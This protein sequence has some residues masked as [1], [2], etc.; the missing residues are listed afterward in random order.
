MKVLRRPVRMRVVERLR[1]LFTRFVVLVVALGVSTFASAVPAAA[2][3]AT[4]AQD[5]ILKVLLFYKSNFHASHVQAR[6][7]V[8]SLANELSVEYGQ[9]VEIEETD[10]AAAFTTGNLATKDAVVFAQT[11]GVLFNTAQRE[12]LEQYIRGG[13]G[14]MGLHYAGW[15]VGQSEHDVNEFYA[16]L[17]GAASEGHPENPA[18][19]PGR[20]VVRDTNH[21]LTQGLAASHTRSDEWYDWLVNPAQNVRTLLSVDESSYSPAVG[22]QGTTHPVT[23][24]Q[25]IDN[26]RSWYTSMGHEGSHYSESYMRTQMRHGLAFATGLLAA[27][28]SPPRKDVQGSWGGVVP[29]PLMPINASLTAEGLVQS[30]GSVGGWGTDTT[31]YDWTGNSTVTQGG[32]FE[33]DVWDP[34]EPRNLANLHDHIVPNNTYTDLFCSMQVQ[35]PHRRTVMTMGGDDSLGT[36]DPVNAAI[37]VTSFSTKTGLV[38]EAPMHYPRWYP[39]ATTM[40][41]G[42]IAVQGGSVRGVSGPGVTTPELYSPNEGAGW[43]LLT[44]AQSSAAYGDTE[45]RW[46][47]PRAFVAPGSGNLFNISGTQMFDLDPYANDGKGKVTLRGTVPSAIADQGSDLGRPVGATSSA[48]MYQPG[49]ILQVGGG[50]WSNGGGGQGARGG[51]TIDITDG[52]ESPVVKATKPMQYHRHWSTATL[53]PDGNVIV[54]GGGAGNN[55]N[56]RYVTNP[57]IWDAATGE[58]ATVEVPYEHARLYHSIALLLPDGRVMIGGGGAPGPRN[59]TDVEFYSPAYLF[60]GD[61]LAVRPEITDAPAE[62]GYNGTFQI[63]ADS[64]VS[65]V[66]L[67]RNGSV[68]HGF[69]NDQ[70]FQELEFTQ[71][72]DSLTVAAPDD[73]TYAP[74]GAYMVFV[75]NEHGTPSKAAML[76]VDPE[77]E[78]DQRTPHVVDQ[79]EYPRVPTSWRSG[80]FPNVT[81][82][83]AGDGRMAPWSVDNGPV[84]LVRGAASTNGGLGV[85][86]THLALGTTAKIERQI[87]GLD[88][89]R[90]YRIS[91][92]YARDSRTP[93]SAGDAITGLSIG[94]LTA[95]IRA[96]TDTPSQSSQAVTFGTY[97]G[98]FT[99][100]KR[101]ESLTLAST[102]GA[103]MMVDDLVIIG[104]DPG[105]NDVPIHYE[106]EEGSGTSAANTGTRHSVGA[107]K[108]R[109]GAGWSK[110]GVF[111][112]ALDL[113]GT[114]GDFVDLPD[115]LLQGATDF[116]V[117][118]WAK[119]DERKAW[120][121]LFQVGNGAGGSG[122]SQGYFQIQSDTRTNGRTGLAATFKEPGKAL[123]ERILL[124]SNT[125]L[126]PGTWSHVAF[127]REGTVG[128]LYLDGQKIASRSDLTLG[129][130]QVGNQTDNFLGKNGYPDD[131]LAGQLDEV[132]IYTSAISAADVAALYGD[133]AALRTTTT[134]SVAP[135]SPSPFGEP[136]TVSTTVKGANGES[137]AGSVE[138]WVAGARVGAAVDLV[139]GSATF[140]K[141]TLNR[142]DHEIEVRYLPADGWRASSAVVAHTVDRP[143]PGEGVPIRYTFDEGSG[144]TAANTGYDTSIGNAQLLGSTGFTQNGRF[145]SAANLPGGSSTSGNHIKLPD[146]IAQD[147]DEEFSVSI[148]AHPRSLPNW[149]PLLQI[150][151]STDTFFVLQSSTQAAGNTGFAATFKAPG[152]PSSAQERLWLGGGNDLPLNKWTHVVFTMSG[153]TGRIYFDGELKATRTDFTVGIGDVGINRATTANFIGG[154]S[155]PDQRFNGM[156]DEFQMF[157]HELSRAEIQ[158]LFEG[159]PELPVEVTAQAR[160]IAGKAYVA[161][162]ARNDHNAAVDITLESAYGQRSFANVAPGGNAYQSFATRAA[163]VPAGSVTVRVT[164]VVDGRAVAIVLTAGYAG[165]N[166]AADPRQAQ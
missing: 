13:G 98:T 97:V 75:F 94:S 147:F 149:V 2:A 86:G 16:R 160:C 21:P 112:S 96:G 1:R 50:G 126:T 140:P 7:A 139:A 65:R 164:A 81:D 107:A 87:Q 85:V 141:L 101:S 31:P 154:I 8:R 103:G 108:L 25:D 59:Y 134:V 91:L 163:S 144:N 124:D 106:F 20:V 79:F 157:G 152:T 156:V 115:N 145:R 148:W 32:Q 127:T 10:N 93:G 77:V 131:P 67:V 52:T 165:L 5:G 72:G 78:M 68:T 83:A 136:L 104:V 42:D 36:N 130:P 60:D 105:L 11:G 119:I 53:M 114:Q 118:M 33:T 100:S 95:S 30:F 162:Q 47:Y 63:T 17:V 142:G 120:M 3:P 64:P 4:A 153:S 159:E 73:A 29:W 19:R 128:T 132:R 121:P 88:P 9:P 49:K 138:L 80:T 111:G 44:G 122:L 137:A 82:V 146:N 90:E 110:D 76:H 24:C 39:T 70:R 23:W 45:N 155:F 57:E 6:E 26:G 56:D 125:D 74:P 161:V 150:G 113:P 62:I 27:D 71:S 166:C 12:A 41:N 129:L 116:S 143:A 89:G 38:D 14:Y 40:P 37:G 43:R 48:V 35:N 109:G 28:C 158:K 61:E 99:A 117:S 54:T 123:E 55:N 15:S 18:V 133:G 22:R 46:W 58:W 102:G 69:N 34:D 66:T 135:K 84:Q 151:D 92:R 51:L